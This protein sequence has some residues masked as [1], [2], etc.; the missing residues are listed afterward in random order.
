MFHD[1]N[2]KLLC[3]WTVDAAIAAALSELDWCS[4]KKAKNSSKGFSL[5]NGFGK[6]LVEKRNLSPQGCDAQQGC[7]SP[8]WEA[9]LPTRST[10]TEEIFFCPL[11]TWQTDSVHPVTFQ[12]FYKGTRSPHLV[13]EP[14]FRN[15][16]HTTRLLGSL[17]HSHYTTSCHVSGILVI[18]WFT[19]CDWAAIG[20]SHTIP[21]LKKGLIRQRG[22]C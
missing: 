8:Q 3:Q 21:C 22:C 5:L 13:L 19:L 10:S 1:K 9:P 20:G 14:G 7:P 4:W 18:M 15:L 16:V 17:C 2:R 12:V 11:F 6:F